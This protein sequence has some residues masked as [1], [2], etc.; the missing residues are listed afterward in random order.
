MLKSMLS[1]ASIVVA[2]HEFPQMEHKATLI[3]VRHAYL[4]CR[5]DRGREEVA[6]Q[7]T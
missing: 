6:P 4:T 5:R 7:F 1:I 2:T 3:E